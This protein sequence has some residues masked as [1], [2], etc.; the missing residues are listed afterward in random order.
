MDKVNPMLENTQCEH[1]SQS[2]NFMVVFSLMG[3]TETLHLQ[4]FEQKGCVWFSYLSMFLV[5]FV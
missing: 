3:W 5:F 4:P 2:E 1:W